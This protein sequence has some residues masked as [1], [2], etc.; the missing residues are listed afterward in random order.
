MEKLKETGADVA[1]KASKPNKD[2]G[3]AKKI[4]DAKAA[5]EKQKER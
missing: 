2:A 4:A 1:K 3:K 5:L